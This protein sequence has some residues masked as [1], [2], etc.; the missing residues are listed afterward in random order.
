[1]RINENYPPGE[2]EYFDGLIRGILKRRD[3]GLYQNEVTVLNEIQILID[4]TL[5]LYAKSPK[6]DTVLGFFQ[7]LSG[8][9]LTSE[10]R[11]II[12]RK[13]HNCQ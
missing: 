1:M 6:K 4:E 13:C 9:S 3:L 5:K 7:Q 12:V 10:A 8:I 11:P 2:E